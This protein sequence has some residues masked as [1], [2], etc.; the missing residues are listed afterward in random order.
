MVS[1]NTAEKDI[2][3]ICGA[4]IVSCYNFIQSLDVNKLYQSK[5]IH[6][7]DSIMS[8]YHSCVIVLYIYI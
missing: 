7:L 8:R 1:T 2:K 6:P 3:K 4:I 5:Y